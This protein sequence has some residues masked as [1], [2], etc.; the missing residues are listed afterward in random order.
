MTN[1]QD[2]N[3]PDPHQQQWA[4]TQIN[5]SGGQQMPGAPFSDAAYSGGQQYPSNTGDLWSAPQV[6]QGPGGYGPGVGPQHPGFGPSG[7][8]PFGAAGSTGWTGPGAPPQKSNKGLFIG[9]GIGAAVLVIVLVV[10]LIAVFAGGDDATDSPEAAVQT[11]LD[12]LAAGDAKK[13]LSVSVT[14]ASDVLLTDENLKKQREL[15]PITNITVRK[16]DNTLGSMATVNATYKH[17]DKNVDEDI[18][19]RKSGDVWRVD[20]GALAITLSSTGRAPGLS[21]FGHDVSAD[22]KVYVFPGP[23]VWGSSNANISVAD[24]RK[25]FPLGPEDYYYP[26]LQTS[27]SPT[28]K[29]VVNAALDT[30]FTNCATSTQ[31]KASDDRPGCSQSTYRSAVPGSVRWTKPTDVSALTT[32]FDYDDAS[33]VKVSGTVYWGLSYTSTYAGPQTDT[34]SEYLSGTVDLSQSTPTFT[35][36]N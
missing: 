2:P 36:S 29:Q 32:R 5:Q 17:G 25:E 1:P 28:G 24:S 4:Q 20:N 10:A 26:S 30:Y 9:V 13:A 16:P 19:V 27:L 23:L 18:R 11:Y 31:A 35:S 6:Q 8:Q 34:D 12:A 33:K 15:A 14:P 3:Q 21:L 22:T 7:P